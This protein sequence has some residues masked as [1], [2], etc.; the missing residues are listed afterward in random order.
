MV[1][2]VEDY[3][4]ATRC[5]KYSRFNHRHQDCR[6][7]ETCPLYAGRHKMK[8]CTANSSEYKCIN[9]ATYN[10]HNKNAS[11]C[12]THNLRQ[13]LSQ[14]PSIIRKIQAKHRL[15]KWRLFAN[16]TQ[17]A[18]QGN[19][20]QSHIRC[21]QIKLQHSKVTTAN[22]MQITDEKKHW[23]TLHS[24]NL[25][26]AEQSGWNTKQFQNLYNCRDKK[27]SSYCGN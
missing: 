22:I 11:L 16:S 9:C 3:L 26:N 24:E 12:N 17:H 5:F 18:T 15:L 8:E 1:F 14:S 13:K 25:H 6:G 10:F 23:H 19:K 4:V 21:I 20:K 27:Q 2:K 7:E